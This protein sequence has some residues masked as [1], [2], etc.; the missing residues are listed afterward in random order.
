MPPLD[1]ERFA[2]L[3][4]PIRPVRSRRMAIGV[5]IAQA[6]VLGVMALTVSDEGP[7]GFQW[8]DRAGVFAV[9]AAVFAVLWRFASVVAVPSQE[10]LRVRNLVEV[11]DLEWAEIV[12]V[13]F[14]GG[15][16]WGVLDLSDGQS[17]NVMALQRSDGETA[18]ANSTR[19][20]TLVALHSRTAR[21]D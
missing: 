4:A 10:G 18:Q 5:G 3:H 17:L 15:A 1:D 14:G 21:D 7:L 12:T 13:R 2:A 9:A 11:R 20:A 16:P 19:L 8:Y 6:I